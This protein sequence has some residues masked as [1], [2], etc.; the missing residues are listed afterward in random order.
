[1]IEI[2]AEKQKSG[3][4]HHIQHLGHSR[5]VHGRSDTDI[6]HSFTGT[7]SIIF[8]L[9]PE[10]IV[11]GRYVGIC[12]R[13]AVIPVP[14]AVY[15]VHPVDKLIVFPVAERGEGYGKIV[16]IMSELKLTGIGYILF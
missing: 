4:H 1:M 7:F 11:A 3:E 9:C 2:Y 10:H 12:D 6:Q 5:E 8:Q 13:T 15:T 14:L 16:L